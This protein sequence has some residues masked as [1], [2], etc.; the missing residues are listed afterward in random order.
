MG[1]TMLWLAVGVETAGW[2]GSLLIAFLGSWGLLALMKRTGQAPAGQDA[3]GH[4]A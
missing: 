4:R 1:A 3:H 2:L